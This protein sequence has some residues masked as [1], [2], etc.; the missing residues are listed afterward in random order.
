MTETM[1]E[2]MRPLRA[3]AEPFVK[4]G[5]LAPQLQAQL[6]EGLTIRDGCLLLISQVHNIRRQNADAFGG[7][8][9]FEGY[10]NKLPMDWLIDGADDSQTWQDFVGTSE[11]AA[12][13]L[14]QSI[15]LGH[16]VAAAAADLTQAP[17]DVWVSVDYGPDEECPSTDFRFVTYREDDLWAYNIAGFEQPVLR[18]TSRKAK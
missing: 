6:D 7:P 5:R 8:T 15:L 9:G 10:I 1:N 11:W 2:A 17:I 13:C 3:L 12:R 14:A 16:G 4:S 18:V